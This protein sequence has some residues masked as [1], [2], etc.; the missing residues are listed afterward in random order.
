M[1]E[2]VTGI[3][4]WGA[5]IPR[6]R[7]ARTTIAQAHAW[8]FPSL[9]GK[10]EK[11]FCN[12]D[13]DVIT[14]AVEAGRD[15]LGDCAREPLHCLALASTSAP[16]ADL[17]NSTLIASALR[18][19][20]PIACSDVGGSTRAG[21]TELA[22]RLSSPIEGSGGLLL[23]SEKRSAK[24]ASAQELRYGCGAAA[25]QLGSEN[26]AAR[27][28][29][30]HCS[31]TPLVDHFRQNGIKYDYYG[32]ERWIR[33]EG[34]GRLVPAAIRE[35][36]DRLQLEPARIAYFGLAGVPAGSDAQVARKLGIAPTVVSPLLT[37]KV[38][39]TGTAHGPLLLV[40]ALE[41]TQPGDI[42]L[43]A[44]FGQGCEV[45]AFQRE[46]GGRPPRQGL[47]ASI[48]NGILQSTYLKMLSFEGEIELDWGPRAE[49]DNKAALTQQY[50]STE[51][52]LGFVGG[53]CRACGTV[54]F[55]SLATC[56][57][58]TASDS[59][60]P[61]PIADSPARLA[62]YSADWLQYH[63]APP[64]YIGLV[65]FDNGARVLMEIVDV[66]TAGL[67]V[68]TR[69]DMVFRIKTRDTRRHYDRYF[70]K[71]SPQ[72]AGTTD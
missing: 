22:N 36:L 48:D 2:S 62:T 15:C 11:A 49:T 67:E 60:E 57:H 61:H 44:A 59:Q 13:E 30:R 45:L 27:F 37:D 9:R 35:L 23:A 14:L 5:Y 34:V 43:I 66:G 33:D 3:Q 31:S 8:A 25:L 68:G 63:P 17:Q 54:Q 32:E 4:S 40:E 69:L 10:G 21:L 51:Q 46:S 58:C 65:Q 64:L 71:A 56:L 18:L 47:K 53:R 7:M 26:L 12:W 42:I 24:P 72:A 70:W 41:S 6:P 29:G 50:R 55:P 38:G 39:D 16:F 52:I 20:N 1:R 28:L 19:E